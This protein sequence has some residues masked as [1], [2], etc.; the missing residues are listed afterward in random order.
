MEFSVQEKIARLGKPTFGGVKTKIAEYSVGPNQTRF[1]AVEMVSTQ[2][3]LGEI[4]VWA[5]EATVLVKG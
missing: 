3:F 5:V 4:L 1:H 2:M